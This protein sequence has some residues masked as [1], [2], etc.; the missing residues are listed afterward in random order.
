MT[1]GNSKGAKIE[2]GDAKIAPEFRKNWRAAEKRRGQQRLAGIQVRHEP[3]ILSLYKDFP[4]RFAENGSKDPPLQTTAPHGETAV[5][6][7]MGN[8]TGCGNAQ[9][10]ASRNGFVSGVK[11]VGIA[12]RPR[13]G[14]TCELS[15]M[16]G[17]CRTKVRPLQCSGRAGADR[18]AGTREALPG[19]KIVCFNVGTFKRSNVRKTSRTAASA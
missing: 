15:A 5:V 9:R 19:T 16:R 12:A 14:R 2:N 10:C 7:R 3:N 17:P 4:N 1:T 6:N 18:P 8:K 11:R 13:S